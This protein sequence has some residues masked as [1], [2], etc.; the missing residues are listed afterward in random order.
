MSM[1]ATD[2]E[3]T[4]VTP[5]PRRRAAS[6]DGGFA[7]VYFAL[8]L[9]V[10]M[11]MAGLGLDLWNLWRNSQEV[12]RA[13]DAGA[14]A[15][16]TFLPG[17]LPNA[18]DKA[19][20][21][22][23]ANG[24]P[25]SQ[26]TA[27]QG[28][29][30]QQLEVT[31]RTTVRNPFMG[32]LGVDR[33]TIT[34]RAVAEFIGPVPMGSPD[35]NLGNDPEN[36]D[37][38]DHWMNVASVR[39]RAGNGDR[40]QAGLCTGTVLGPC[41]SGVIT[42]PSYSPAG[43]FYAVEVDAAASGPLRIQIFDPALYEVGDRCTLSPAVFNANQGALQ[44]AAVADPDIPDTWH[45]NAAVRYV[46]GNSREW[47]TGDFR[48]GAEGG[49]NPVTTT[50]VVRQPDSTPFVDT[51][52]PPVTDATCQPMQ[53]TGRDDAW[54]RNGGNG[55][56]GH[57]A[58]GPESKVTHGGGFQQTLANSFR[59][60]V[61][62]CEIPV[63]SVGRYILQVRT[64]APD[65][66]PLVAGQDTVN[67][68]GHNRYSI[69]AGT[70]DPA[71]GSFGDSVKLFANGRLPIYANASGADTQFYLARVLPS[72]ADRVLKISLWDISDGGS[73]GSMQVV[74]PAEVGGSFAGCTYASSGGTFTPQGN[75]SFAFNAGALNSQLM[76]VSVPLPAGYT[77]DEN[78]PFGCWI[79]VRAP[80]AGS[81]N[82]TTTWSADVA[83]DPVRLVE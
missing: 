12:Q 71:S 8:A 53:F 81:V 11:A 13:A 56:Q 5:R 2:A 75:C 65:G 54:M 15:G 59:R 66:Q 38:T 7:M 49:A 31:V 28:D 35:N 72:G 18:Q 36:G 21:I 67:S 29:A 62:V 43:H 41:Q 16:V 23:E 44:A 27:T 30:P 64:N 26:A 45:D 51:D 20:D 68:W 82:D 6:D 76:Q 24:Y 37:I 4:A 50:Y 80:F 77:C 14:L 1:T 74:P 70:G 3:T 57:L 34:R 47:C 60:W 63:P 48:A 55:I 40:Y 10:F 19:Y 73:S 39:N 25:R 33:T 42:N 9:I 79:T 17:D 78:D 46:A 22:V 69:R 32:L 83:G 61:T 52:N 58:S